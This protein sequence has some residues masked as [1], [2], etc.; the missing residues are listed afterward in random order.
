M[1]QA[2]FQLKVPCKLGQLQWRNQPRKEMLA[3][4]MKLAFHGSHIPSRTKGGGKEI[5]KY[6]AASKHAANATPTRR[7]ENNLSESNF[8]SNYIPAGKMP[9]SQ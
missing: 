4:V 2:M 3:S 6:L 8:I 9:P 7:E 5:D 1:V